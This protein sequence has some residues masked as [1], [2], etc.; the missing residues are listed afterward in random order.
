MRTLARFSLSHKK[1]Y[2]IGITGSVGKT[3][4]RMIIAELLQQQLTGLKI[5]TSP[6]N[7]NSELGLALSVL[8]I[9]NFSHNV[10]GWIKALLTGFLRALQ[11]CPYD[12][13]VLEYGIDYPGEMEIE[14]SIVQPN[15]SIFTSVDSVHAHQ[16][17]SKE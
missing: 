10:I 13:L 9:E 11:G 12:V 4:C 8:A 1:P 6:S 15:L 16:L 3:S 7:Y 2:V 14:L 17:G 5:Y